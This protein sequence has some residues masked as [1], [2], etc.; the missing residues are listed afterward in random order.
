[1]SPDSSLLRRIIR[2][3]ALYD[4]VVTLPFATPW[5]AE[6]ALSLLLVVVAVVV[7]GAT[8]QGRVPR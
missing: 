1:M 7:I 6:V 5:T 3:S 8:R 2:G 4:L